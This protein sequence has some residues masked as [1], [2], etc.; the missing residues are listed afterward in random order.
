M[1]NNVL[2]EKFASII[3]AVCYWLGY[4][5]KIGREQL[6][7]EA[8][9]RYPIADSITS[10]G[11]AIHRIVL[12]QLHPIFKSKKIDL[13]IYDETVKK[14]ETEKDDSK[15]NEV[16]ELKLA[17][18]KT[19][20]KY[21]DEHQRVFD[22]VVRLAY[23]NLWGN[24]ECYFLMC[25]TYENFKTYFVGQK[26]EVK[27]QDNKNTVTPRYAKKIQNSGQPTTEE[28]QPVGLYKDWFSFT[29]G[30]PKTIKF[31]TIDDK[32]GLKPFQKN[33]EPREEKHKFEATIEIKTTCVALTSIGEKT[34]TH[35]AGI[36]K[37]EA[38]FS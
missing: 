25:G 36:W 26:S 13:V 20:E 35:A 37:I 5:M 23:Y 19:A 33:Y 18:S 27:Y 7:H 28:W 16:Y 31:D 1:H 38:L 22:D 30:E 29:I 3:D 6:I 34:K 24:K 11:T 4:Q 10:K 2:D 21:S 12:E 17:K 32:W 14:P 15:L 9:L 8:S